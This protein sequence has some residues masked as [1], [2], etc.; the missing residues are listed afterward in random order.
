MKNNNVQNGH[1]LLY[2]FI[3]AVCWFVMEDCTWEAICDVKYWSQI[4][5]SMVEQ[6]IHFLFVIGGIICFSYFWFLF[7]IYRPFVVDCAVSLL[8]LFHVCL[9]TF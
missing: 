6:C 3:N 9:V 8:R 1:L 7:T 2:L 5:L 4:Y